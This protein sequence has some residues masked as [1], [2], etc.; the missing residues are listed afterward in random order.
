MTTLPGYR[1][2]VGIEADLAARPNPYRLLLDEL[3]P[4]ETDEEPWS[5]PDLNVLERYGNPY[6]VA[7]LVVAALLAAICGVI[8]WRMR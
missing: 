8:A 4:P 2:I 5:S 7:V 6:T 3:R 1:E